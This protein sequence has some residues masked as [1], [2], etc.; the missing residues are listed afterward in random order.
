MFGLQPRQPPTVKRLVFAVAQHLLVPNDW[1]SAVAHRL[2][3]APGLA[4]VRHVVRSARV[5]GSEHTLR[6]AF[7]ADFHAGPTTHASQIA[8]ACDAIAASEPHLVLL[9]GDFVGHR[10][11]DIARVAARI[12]ALVPPLGVFGVLGNHDNH[13]NP[14]LVQRSLED[15]GVRMLMNAA[16]RLPAPFERTRIIGLDDH[17]SGEPDIRGIARD[18]SVSTILLVHQPSGLLDARGYRVDL[19]LAGHTHG[20]QIV[21][22]GGY[23]PITPSGALS[24]TYLA[25]EYALPH[26]GVLVVTRGVGTSTVPF[27]WNAPA[28]LRLITL[29]S[30][31]E[32]IAL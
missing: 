15:A 4:I 8:R 18:D 6:I 13:T 20:G 2:G 27:R 23:A 21:L 3:L 29:H 25:G 19:A 22:P 30:D 31:A 26:G 24:R 5:L 11:R 28:D 16:V 10:P 14:A 7:A 9:G 17:A 12:A 1:P 32:L